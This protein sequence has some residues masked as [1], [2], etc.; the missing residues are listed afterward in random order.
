MICCPGWKSPVL[1]YHGEKSAEFVAKKSEAYGSDGV[2]CFLPSVE[3][4]IRVDQCSQTALSM[5]LAL[6]RCRVNVYLPVFV[7]NL[8][9]DGCAP[10]PPSYLVTENQRSF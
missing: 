9:T 8:S 1:K 10:V 7:M 4:K 5:L 2:T 6:F 3:S